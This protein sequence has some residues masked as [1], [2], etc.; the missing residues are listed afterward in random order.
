ML[1]FMAFV[2]PCEAKTEGETFEIELIDLGN[3]FEIP[4]DFKVMDEN[5]NFGTLNM[6]LS[7][8]DEELTGEIR[9][10]KLDNGYTA[11]IDWFLNMSKI[12]AYL[13]YTGEEQEITYGCKNITITNENGEL[14]YF[15]GRNAASEYVIYMRDEEGNV[16]ENTYAKAVM[17]DGYWAHKIHTVEDNEEINQADPGYVQP[18]ERS[19]YCEE[20]KTT[21]SYIQYD[22]K[23]DEVM[24][25]FG[26]Y[27]LNGNAVKIQIPLC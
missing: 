12:G 23:E 14:V 19:T 27:V 5:G 26:Y 21:N 25:G 10:V 11:R 22:R 8:Y 18:I 2:L 6:N 3:G 17:M 7:N 24:T 15:A 1:I 20:S 4:K 9:E 13:D 16:I